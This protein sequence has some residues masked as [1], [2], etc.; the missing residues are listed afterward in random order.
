L[1]IVFKCK[2]CGHVLY[3]VTGSKSD[4]LGV[5]SSAEVIGWHGGRCPKCGKKLE[6]P[7]PED[8]KVAVFYGKK[9]DEELGQPER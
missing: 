2:R 3:A 6:L 9:P 7:K 1:P 8:V 5:P 4:Y